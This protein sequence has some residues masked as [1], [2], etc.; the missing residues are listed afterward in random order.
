MQPAPSSSDLER[1]ARIL[2]RY[3]GAGPR[4]TSYP[5]VPVWR[6]GFGEDLHRA[7]LARVAMQGE[8]SLYTHVPFCRSLCHFCA[9]NRVITRDPALPERWLAALERELETTRAAMGRVPPVVQLHWGGGTPTHLEP[10]QIERLFRATTDHFPLAPGAERSIEVDPRV[11]RADHVAALAAC[12]FDRISMGVQDTDPRTQAA[13]HRLQPFEQTRALTER[14]RAAGIDRVAFDLIYGLPFQT[15]ASIARTLDAVL[16]LEPDRIAL[17]AYAHVTWVAKQ[18]RGFERG[19][20]PGP[21]RRMRILLV[22]I[23]RLLAAGYRAIG[24]DHFVRPGDDLARA[25]DAGTLRRNFMGYTTREGVDVV[26]FGPSAISELAG[27]YV[28]VEKD[29][30]AWSNAALAGRL[31][32]A[33]GHVLSVDDAKRRAIIRDLMCRGAVSAREIDARFGG[34]LLR[35]LAPAFARLERFGDDGL[36]EWIAPGELRV[37]ATGRLFLRPVAMLFDAY[38]EADATKQVGTFSQ[39]V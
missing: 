24:M 31:A 8:I 30:A 15:E 2:P 25:L 17:Y 23:E 32:T 7:A 19:D 9:C 39:T 11:T 22:A 28:Q 16:S 35:D 18:Q 4:Y 34:D 29:L 12:G 21:E 13:I 26:A 5:T 36:V 14:V 1:I 27:T 37:T 38:L 3:V 6:D 20:L 33:R 10:A